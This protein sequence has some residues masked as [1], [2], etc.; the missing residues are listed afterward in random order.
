MHPRGDVCGGISV[1]H[2]MDP[3]AAGREGLHLPAHSGRRGAARGGGAGSSAC[4]GC[5]RG[6]ERLVMARPC[7]MLCMLAMARDDCTPRRAWTVRWTA[8]LCAIC[9]DPHICDDPLMSDGISDNSPVSNGPAAGRSWGWD[10]DGGWPGCGRWN[11][12]ETAGS[13][14]H[15]SQDPRFSHSVRWRG[16]ARPRDRQ[17]GHINESDD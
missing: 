5:V 8:A 1:M 17:R 10:G 2:R 13:G 9:D 16:P 14:G 3:T 15:I 11:V 4:V 6:R 7:A 12:P